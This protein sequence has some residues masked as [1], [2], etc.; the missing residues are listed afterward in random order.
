[1]AHFAQLDENNVV[2][3]VIVIS[4]D[5]CPDPAPENEKLGQDFINQVL[6]L[7]GKFVQTS[8]NNNFRKRSAGIGY[9]F[10]EERDAFIP[11]KAFDSWILNEETCDWEAPIPRPEEGLWS[12][13]EELGNW[14]EIVL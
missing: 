1:M 5:I 10:D 6:Q 12:W 11:I 7:N 9:T 2:I 8:Y 3:Q 14:E 13:N 4:N